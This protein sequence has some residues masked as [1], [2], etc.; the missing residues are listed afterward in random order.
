MI[1]NLEQIF[2]VSV[3]VDFGEKK[4]FSSLLHLHLFSGFAQIL[5]EQIWCDVEK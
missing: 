3:C 2:S 1:K 4:K 5:T